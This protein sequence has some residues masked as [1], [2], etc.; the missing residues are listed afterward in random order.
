M[1]KIQIQYL[2]NLRITLDEIDK[3]LSSMEY[4]W[5]TKFLGGGGRPKKPNRKDITLLDQ[6]I[7]YLQTY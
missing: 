1:R 5:N 6:R 4:N 3:T 7:Q 2:I